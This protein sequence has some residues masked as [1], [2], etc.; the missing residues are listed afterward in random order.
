MRDLLL[1]YEA[2]IVNAI[3]LRCGEHP[4]A[5]FSH[6][7]MPVEWSF[8]G[9]AWKFVGQSILINFLESQLVQEDSDKFRSDLKELVES[10]QRGSIMLAHE[11]LGEAFNVRRQGPRSAVVIAI[12][13]V[14]VAIKQF[15]SERAPSHL[16]WL[17]ES[18]PQRRVIDALRH[19]PNL[20]ETRKGE[21]LPK[22]LLGRLDRGMRLR[23]ATVHRGAVVEESALDEAL[24]AVRDLLYALDYYRGLDW[25]L[26]FVNRESRP[27]KA[28]GAPNR[29]IDK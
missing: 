21:F 5:T 24:E 15:I 20:S 23:H 28:N 19:V 18:L 17:A 11:L 27:N 4:L 25:A 6:P 29:K 9:S 16:E 12:T 22:P 1:N 14:E 10:A 8:D 3:R 2:K 7:E 13:A 26:E